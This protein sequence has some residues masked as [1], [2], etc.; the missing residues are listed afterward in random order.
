MPHTR[1]TPRCATMT[2]MNVKAY[3]VLLA[4]A[5]L[6]LAIGGWTVNGVRRLFAAPRPRLASA[7][8]TLAA[9]AVPLPAVIGS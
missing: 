8:A 9:I 1:G 4:L 2:H 5:I 6:V 3:L 7:A